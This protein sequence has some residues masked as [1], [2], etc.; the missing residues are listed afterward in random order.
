MEQQGFL[1]LSEHLEKRSEHIDPLSGL[2][3]GKRYV[4]L[5]LLIGA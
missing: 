5:T 3:L 2:S 1:S 4:Q